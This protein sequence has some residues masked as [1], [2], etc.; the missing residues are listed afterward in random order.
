MD[1]SM[2]DI[3]DSTIADVT[4]E[5]ELKLKMKIKIKG[6]NVM[7]GFRQLAFRGIINTPVKPWMVD[8]ASQGANKV[9]VT[10]D[11]VLKEVLIDEEDEEM[12]EQEDD[13]DNTT[14]DHQSIV[15]TT[16]RQEELSNHFK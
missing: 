12:E 6:K 9:Y 13:D 3:L 2:K 1:T 16:Q 7:E 11:G 4:P 8:M 15:T 5:E 10:D 14:V